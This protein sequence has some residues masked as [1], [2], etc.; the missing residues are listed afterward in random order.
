MGGAAPANGRILLSPC[1][2]GGKY[3]RRLD[4]FT[5]TEFWVLDAFYTLDD[6][7]KFSLPITCILNLEVQIQPFVKFSSFSSIV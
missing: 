1:R 5:H 2:H 6:R 3:V 7:P 4:Y